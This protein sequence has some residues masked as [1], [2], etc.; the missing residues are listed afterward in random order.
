[1]AGEDPL[2]DAFERMEAYARTAIGLSATAA[3][4]NVQNYATDLDW[5]KRWL[6][7]QYPEHNWDE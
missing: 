3:M 5:F 2:N 4:Q 1:M 7:E 6:Q